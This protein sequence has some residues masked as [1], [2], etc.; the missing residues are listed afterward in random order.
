MPDISNERVD[1]NAIRQ[2]FPILREQAHSHQMIYF[3]NAA[4]SQK[5][6]PVI[7]ALRNYYAEN[8]ANVRRGLHD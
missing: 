7:D 8:N 6:R 1:W 5:P 4:T 2:D 3:D